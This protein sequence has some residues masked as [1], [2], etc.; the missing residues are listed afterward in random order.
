MR[1]EFG[2]GFEPG[3]AFGSVVILEFQQK[4]GDSAS[5]ARRNELQQ[6]YR[7]AYMAIA[8]RC[9][10]GAPSPVA[11]CRAMTGEGRGGEREEHWIIATTPLKQLPHALELLDSQEYI[12]NRRDGKDLKNCTH[13]HKRTE[14]KTR[15]RAE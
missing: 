3:G 12:P 10:R 1:S 11:I 2:P 6:R 13:T 4:K 7:N 5:S 8:W 9:G 15:L 14:K